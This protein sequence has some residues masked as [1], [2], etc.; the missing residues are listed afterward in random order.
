MIPGCMASGGSGGADSSGDFGPGGPWGDGS[1]WNA[2]GG[3]PGGR[4]G[5]VPVT[6]SMLQAA[7]SSGLAV[8]CQCGTWDLVGADNSV[9][10]WKIPTYGLNC[11]NWGCEGQM[12]VIRPGGWYQVPGT[13][14][15]WFDSPALVGGLLLPGMNGA[16]QARNRQQEGFRRFRPVQLCLRETGRRLRHW[17]SSTRWP[18]SLRTFS[19]LLHPE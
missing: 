3:D 4:L 1:P 13:A 2:W 8:T 16:L 15:G 7:F 12:S 6:S 18:S 14:G 17:K 10:R 19:R 11:D 5:G 9:W